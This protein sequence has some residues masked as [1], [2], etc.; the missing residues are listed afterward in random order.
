[1]GVFGGPHR[2][3]RLSCGVVPKWQVWEVHFCRFA[4]AHRVRCLR[5][6][7]Y[8]T[9]G[10]AFTPFNLFPT[11]KPGNDTSELQAVSTAPEFMDRG[12]QVGLVG[13]EVHGGGCEASSFQLQNCPSMKEDLSF[14][15]T[16]TC[17]NTTSQGLLKRHFQHNRNIMALLAQNASCR[18]PPQCINVARYRQLLYAF[19]DV[20]AM[21]S[22]SLI[23]D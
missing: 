1:M 13:S 9:Q 20:L 19:S 17:S 14:Y 6:N 4:L 3:A 10:W 21:F 18:P 23:V 8:C 7:T 11:K 22:L 12:G 5:T 15:R 2:N 16:D